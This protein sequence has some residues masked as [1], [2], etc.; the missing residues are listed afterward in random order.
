MELT[1]SGITVT[2][3]LIREAN[4]KD[5]KALALLDEICF[6]NPWSAE[7]IRH[8]IEFGEHL[9]YF[10]A[11][12]DNKIIGYICAQTILDEC[13]IRRVC[14]HPDL[15]RLNVAS[16]LMQALIHVSEEAGV[17]CHTLEVKEGNEAALG[18]YRNFG[19]IENGRRAGYYADGSDAI[20]MLRLGDPSN[21]DPEMSA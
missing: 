8:D 12:T 19:F 5:V 11:Q 21:V 15:R 10:V 1:D 2:E 17:K 20:L 13:D 9:I 3:L 14:V 16:I 7:A 4:I 6:D 18:L